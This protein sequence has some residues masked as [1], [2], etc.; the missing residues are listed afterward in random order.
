MTFKASHIYW[1]LMKP[2]L[3]IKTGSTLPSLIPARSDFEHWITSGMGIDGRHITVIDVRDGSALPPYGQVSGVVITGSHAMV[4][5]HQAWSERTAAWL[6][7]AIERQIPLLGI[8]Y[9]HQLLAYALGGQVGDNPSGREFGTVPITLN[10]TAQE[11]R[12][13][14]GLPNRVMAYVSHSQSVLNLPDGATRLASSEKD[15][16]QIFV[17]GGCAWGV[18]FHPEFDVKIVRTYITHYRET[19]LAEGQD[20]DRLADACGEAPI[21]P[22]ILRRFAAI[23]NG[24]PQS[25]TKLTQS[26]KVALLSL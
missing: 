17:V 21:G 25:T 9:G 19:L 12:L 14:G 16:N 3:I 15:G 18:Q 20:P 4:T 24:K 6:P 23:V 10:E 26:T 7:G 11:D 2:L 22:E 8:C 13:L 1:E 5:E